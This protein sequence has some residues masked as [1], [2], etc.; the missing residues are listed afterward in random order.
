M[1]S[2]IRKYY[3]PILVIKLLLN[4]NA[5]TNIYFSVLRKETLRHNYYQRVLSRDISKDEFR[6]KSMPVK[7]QASKVAT[8]VGMM[9]VELE[10]G[11]TC[12]SCLIFP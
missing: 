4:N 10:T 9:L 1:Y 6:S 11:A 3:R 7:T 5:Y 2:L 8:S 12:S